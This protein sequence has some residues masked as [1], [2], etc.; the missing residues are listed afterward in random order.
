M[1]AAF[2]LTRGEWDFARTG[3]GWAATLVEKGLATFDE[4]GGVSLGRELRLVADEAESAEREEIEPGVCA[5]RGKRF[6]MVIEPYRLIP[7]GL[8]ISLYRDG[9]ALEEAIRERGGRDDG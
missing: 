9:K 1:T 6:C 3:E 5:L 8:K 7:D 2:I 4:D